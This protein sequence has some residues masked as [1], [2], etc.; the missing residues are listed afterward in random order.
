M[1]FERGLT[2]FWQRLLGFS[3]PSQKRPFLS[4]KTVDADV[5]VA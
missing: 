4:A 5:L 2:C 3:D 1:S